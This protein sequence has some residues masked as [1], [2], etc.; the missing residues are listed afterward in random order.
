MSDFLTPAFIEERRQQLLARERTDL[1]RLDRETGMPD[2]HRH[3]TI[4]VQL[5]DVRN[6]L[7][8]IVTGTY[9]Y[10]CD[11]G[12]PIHEARLIAKPEAVRCLDCQRNYER[13]HKI[14]IPRE[15]LLPVSMR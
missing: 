14:E 13:D 5:P 4:T 9:G 10:C 3:F 15:R 2:A 7:T 1:E 11:C 8:R 6:A 12:D